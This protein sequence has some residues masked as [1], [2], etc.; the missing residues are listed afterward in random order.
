MEVEVSHNNY[1]DNHD[2]IYNKLFKFIK[3]TLTMLLE[4]GHCPRN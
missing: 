1:G 3:H 2:D 4:L